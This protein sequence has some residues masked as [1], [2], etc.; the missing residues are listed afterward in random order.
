MKI[1]YLFLPLYIL[2]LAVQAATISDFDN[3]NVKIHDLNTEVELRKAQIELEQFKRESKKALKS[4]AADA[5]IESNENKV[6]QLISAYKLKLNTLLFQVKIG[7]IQLDDIDQLILRNKVES[8]ILSEENAIEKIKIDFKQLTKLL[9][10]KNTELEHIQGQLIRSNN[11]LF[12]VRIKNSQNIDKVSSNYLRKLT[13]CN[14]KVNQQPLFTPETQVDETPIKKEEIDNYEP[15]KESASLISNVIINDVIIGSSYISKRKAR[16]SLRFSYTIILPPIEG[17]YQSTP[18]IDGIK[19]ITLNGFL[20][21]IIIYLGSN[22]D[23]YIE[24]TKGGAIRFFDKNTTL[25]MVN[26]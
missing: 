16:V 3:K 21:P 17:G 24:I 14:D 2:A 11:D 19:A 20:K 7:K 23:I 1:R 9:E 15:V 25:K 10:Q 26:L 18:T 12:D 6:K 8:I 4:L 13:E 22:S 5:I